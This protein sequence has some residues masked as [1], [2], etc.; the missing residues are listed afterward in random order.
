[1]FEENMR[2]GLTGCY[3]RKGLHYYADK[4]LDDARSTGKHLYVCVVDLNGLKNLNDKYGHENG[5]TAI[6]TVSAALNSAAPEEVRAV[7]TGGD[8]FLLIAALPQ[9]SK[10]PNEIEDK[11]EKYLEEYNKSHHN[12]FAVGASYGSVFLP[13]KEGMTDLDEYIGMADSKM[14]KMKKQRDPNCR[15]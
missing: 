8:E 12:P 7:R 15:E 5:D 2:D 14:Y 4:V 10:E 3:N 9:N 11:I 6:V 1:M 13:L